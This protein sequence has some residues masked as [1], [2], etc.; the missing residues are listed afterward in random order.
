MMT[1]YLIGCKSA[2]PPGD[3]A[4]R[5]LGVVGG[6]A[7]GAQNRQMETSFMEPRKAVEISF[8]DLVAH[9]GRAIVAR[10]RIDRQYR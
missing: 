8:V 6:R 2:G 4:A 5:K 10:R 1:L 9:G 7:I 3:A